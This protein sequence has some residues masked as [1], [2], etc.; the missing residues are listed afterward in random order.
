MVTN[1]STFPPFHFSTSHKGQALVEL[2]V[3]MLALALVVSALCGF[4]LYISK[5]LE[6][7]NKLRV[8]G[9]RSE[10]VDVSGPMAQYLF[11]VEKLKASEKLSWPS[12]IIV[13]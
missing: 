1:F 9:K 2:A 7:Q 12:T 4:A 5:S 13:R 8:G 3:G 11:G 10:T 6:I